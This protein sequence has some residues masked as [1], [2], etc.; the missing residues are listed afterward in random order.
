[1]AAK[2]ICPACGA[3]NRSGAKFCL[4]CGKPLATKETKEQE[5]RSFTLIKQL[6]AVAAAIATILGLLFLLWPSIKP[7]EPPTLSAVLS[8]VSV[9]PNVTREEFLRRNNSPTSG[10]TR[11]QLQTNGAVVAFDVQLKGF[12]GRWCPSRWSIYDAPSD[13]RVP[14]I[15]LADQPGTIFQPEVADDH[16]GDKIWVQFPDRAGSYKVRLEIYD[17]KG[18]LLTHMDSQPVSVTI[19]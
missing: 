11:E 19:R 10:Y 3:T 17:D 7:V 2:G 4:K 13:T 6:G 14:E 8:N 18:V 16:A 1:M 5:P 12:E 15:E 9:E